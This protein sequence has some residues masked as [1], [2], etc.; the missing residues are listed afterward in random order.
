M[1]LLAEAL[2]GSALA[3][4]ELPNLREEHQRLVEAGDPAPDRYALTNVETD[5][6]VNSLNTLSGQVLKW[7]A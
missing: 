5:R 3:A 1:Y 6:V 2:R 7:L 4:E